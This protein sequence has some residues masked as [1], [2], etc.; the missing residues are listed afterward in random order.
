MFLSFSLSIPE[1]FLD[2]I[3]QEVMTLPMLLP[4]GVSVDNATLEEYQKREATWGRAPN[5]PFTGVPFTSTSHV[6]PNPQLKMRIDHFVLQKGVVRRDGM[7][8]RQE[9]RDDPQASRLL[10]SKTGQAQNSSEH[11]I[12]ADTPPQLRDSAAGHS[13][14]NGNDTSLPARTDSDV[15]GHGR[16][17]QDRSC[18][19]KQSPEETADE[20]QLL[21]RAKRA[22]TDAGA[23]IL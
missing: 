3:T 23:F 14:H 13:P 5:D 9:N 2:P 22:R 17:K 12:N 16:R 18:I 1:E 6:L 10:A 11:K 15:G 21:P 19:S 4:C 8:G 7:L 20:K